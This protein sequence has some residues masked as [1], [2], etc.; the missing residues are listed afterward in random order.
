MAS[1]AQMNRDSAATAAANLTVLRRMDPAVEEVLC[2][3][4]RVCLYNF[5]TA[6]QQWVRSHACVS[7]SGDA[8]DA[9]R[10]QRQR[11]RTA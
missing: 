4:P 1:G 2:R 8:P 7:P 5:D 9:R 6:A 10:R 11:L 3:A